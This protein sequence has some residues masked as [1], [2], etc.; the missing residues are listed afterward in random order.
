MVKSNCERPPFQDRS[1]FS[2]LHNAKFRPPYDGRLHFIVV[3]GSPSNFEKELVPHR[4]KK[5]KTLFSEDSF[6]L[7]CAT[8]EL[9]MNITRRHV[10]PPRSRVN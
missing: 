4:S 8:R 10:C 1:G 2:W 6:P 5:V 3:E 7:V 9:Q